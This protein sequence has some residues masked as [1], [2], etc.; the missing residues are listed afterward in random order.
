MIS[1]VMTGESIG[2]LDL[3]IAGVVSL[4]GLVLMTMNVTDPGIG[5][6]VL[7]VPAFLAVTAPLLWRRAAPLAAIALLLAALL[8]HAAL[9]PH[10]VRCG[11]AFAAM[12]LLVF[13]T[14]VREERREALIAL[15]LGLALVV[16]VSQTDNFLDIGVVPV[17]AAITFALWGTGRF[18][19]SRAR[20]VEVLRQR[21]GELRIA[22]DERARLEVAA[23][24]SRLSAELD[25]LL[26]RRLGELARLADGG[27]PRDDPGAATATLVDIEHA[28]RR[29]LEEMRTVV[30]VLRADASGAPTAPQPALTHLE[31]LLLRVS[32]DQA[33][34]TVAGDPRVLP[35]GVELSAYRVVEH[36]LAAL[37][38][39]PRVEV[40]VRFGDDALELTVSAPS[41]RRLDGASVQRARERLRLHRGTLSATQRDGRAVAVAVLPLT[42]G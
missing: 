11:V 21:T 37:E 6:N 36:L 38:D 41:R 34:L 39:A 14:A 33:R 17:F 31:A 20:M 27:A 28:G 8:V 23:D 4:L 9:F 10:L 7:A 25:E 12:F 32:G 19:R 42:A 2:R 22:R 5:A 30:G 18:V 16:V 35:A 29:T 13:S 3:V 26:Q 15:T 24:R 1:T 40:G